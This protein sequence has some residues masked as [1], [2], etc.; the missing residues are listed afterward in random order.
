[1]LVLWY[2]A[3]WFTNKNKPER[4]SARSSG[5]SGHCFGHFHQ[6]EVCLLNLRQT[7]DWWKLT[8]SRSPVQ[9]SFW[10]WV[11]AHFPKQRLVM[12][13]NLKGE[14]LAIS[15]SLNKY[16]PDCLPHFFVKVMSDV[17]KLLTCV[18]HN[19]QSFQNKEN[20]SLRTPLPCP[21]PLQYHAD[22]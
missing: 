18:I 22:L 12:E 14:I 16:P 17:G 8:M 13:P 11:R 9:P 4:K 5:K 21:E 20:S 15:I 10:G 7:S 6:S 19:K 1:M 3:N 2:T